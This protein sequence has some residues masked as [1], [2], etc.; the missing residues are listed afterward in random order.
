MRGCQQLKWLQWTTLGLEWP[1]GYL[2]I[3][4]LLHYTWLWCSL[5][6]VDIFT[7][8]ILFQA[9]IIPPVVQTAYEGRKCT[10]MEENTLS[11]ILISQ[12]QRKILCGPRSR[13]RGL[14][15]L[16]RKADQKQRFRKLAP[17]FHLTSEVLNVK[18]CLRR[19]HLL[20]CKD[21]VSLRCFR[22]TTF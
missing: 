12:L 16:I 10:A 4:L 14:H 2:C 19:L 15:A 9:F 11:W 3:L 1:Q 6:S 20:G 13:G 7:R 5:S 22:Y 8:L 18:P 17:G 21:C